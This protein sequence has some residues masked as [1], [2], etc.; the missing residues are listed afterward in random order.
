MTVQCFFGK[1]EIVAH[2][3][4]KIKKRKAQTQDFVYEEGQISQGQMG[5]RSPAKDDPRY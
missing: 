4:N 3:W 2:S 1:L 5:Q